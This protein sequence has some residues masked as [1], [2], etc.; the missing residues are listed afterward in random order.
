DD[1]VSDIACSRRHFTILK[2]QWK[3]I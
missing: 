3:N 2:N 1:R